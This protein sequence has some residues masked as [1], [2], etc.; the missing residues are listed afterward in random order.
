[1]LGGGG[2]GAGGERRIA[3]ERGAPARGLGTDDVRQLSREYR[4]RQQD[5]EA[6]RRELQRQGMDTKELERAIQRMRALGVES[7]YEDQAEVDRLQSSV[8]ESVK[9]FEFALRRQMNADDSSRPML[10]GNAQVPEQFK[11]LVEEYYRSLAR[12]KKP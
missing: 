6:L 10:G 5:A 2:G 11:A 4:E 8:T 9:A 7:T 12:T 3:G 1:M